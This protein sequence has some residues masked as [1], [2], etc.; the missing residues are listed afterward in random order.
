MGFCFSVR[1]IEFVLYVPGLLGPRLDPHALHQHLLSQ[2]QALARSKEDMLLL[3]MDEYKHSASPSGS[4]PESHNS[5]TSVEVGDGRRGLLGS[6]PA[7]PVPHGVGV[8]VGPAG[9]QHAAK[10]LLMPFSPL[11]SM[12][13]HPAFLPPHPFMFPSNYLPRLQS[14]LQPPPPPFNNNNN[15][16]LEYSKRFYLDSILQTPARLHFR[17]EEEDEDALRR[18]RSPSPAPPPSPRV[19]PL[20]A[21]RPPL[22]DHPMDLSVK[23]SAPS[24]GPSSDRG[25]DSGDEDADGR[26][27]SR[28]SGADDTS[29]ARSARSPRSEHPDED[30]DEDVDVE[31]PRAPERTLRVIPLD[32]SARF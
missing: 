31:V 8:G 9:G 21:S 16:T 15:E 25:R 28:G 24:I 4:S 27:L 23:G 14:G 17:D 18:R 10:D 1:A 7:R 2:Q 22:D 13:P 3:G 32:L 29:D 6:F 20:L 26:P 5:D 12:L 11:A 30:E 19:P